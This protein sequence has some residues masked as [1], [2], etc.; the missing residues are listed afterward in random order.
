MA[1]ADVALVHDYF[2]QD[3]GAERVALELARLL[4]S[5]DVYTSFFDSATFGD[6]LNPARV[7]AWPLNGRIHSSRFRALLPLYPAWFSTLD[8]RRYRLVVS[9][10]SAFAK[11]V[12][13]SRRAV[14]VAYIHSPMR[15]AWQ[16]DDYSGGSSLGRVARLGG[17]LAGGPLRYW[18]RRSAARPNV[19]VANSETVR[20]R[21]RAWWQRDAEVIYPVVDV[22]EFAPA[23]ADQG[24]L[25]V[26]ARLLRHRR[27]DLA[28][29]AANA[30]G[31]ALVVAGD[32]PERATL[33]RRAGP[34]VRFEGH[35]A[36]DRLVEL[37]R[38]CHAY[39]VPGEEDF[40]IA[41]VEAMAA[42]RPVVALNRGGATETV[43]NGV[44]GVLFDDQSVAGVAAALER[45]DHLQLDPAR[46]R[47]QAERFDRAAF[48]TAWHSLFAR[49]GVDQ[50]VLRGVAADG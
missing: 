45:L 2:V 6:R 5:A 24:Y 43:V 27:L 1:D 19:L 39:V 22:A 14:H 50:A 42:G 32:G 4:P 41:L 12:R 7:H 10:S 46:I 9:S 47:A 40:G 3:G 21:I 30:L 8:L 38:G 44:S 49:L 11:A 20:R 25:L 17:R 33:S 35:V 23:G 26:A 28:V 18:D 16:F 31:M 36:R 29:D 37:V 34:T 15:F 13:T 48:A